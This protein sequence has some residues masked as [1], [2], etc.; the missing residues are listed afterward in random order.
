MFIASTLTLISCYVK[1]AQSHKDT[2]AT[3]SLLDIHDSLLCHFI[4]WYKVW[5]SNTCP[6]LHYAHNT[7]L[8]HHLCS[9]FISKQQIPSLVS[10]FHV[11]FLFFL[12]QFL[13]FLVLVVLVGFVLLVLVLF[14]VLALLVLVFL[15]R[16]SQ[17]DFLS[18]YY[19]L[20]FGGIMKCVK[21]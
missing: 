20:L 12:F 19:L 3:R 5:D 13:F 10:S 11:L 4:D 17:V 8:T 18:L 15:V 14:V 6:H 21:P 16:Y 7:M 2:L 9:S 1:K